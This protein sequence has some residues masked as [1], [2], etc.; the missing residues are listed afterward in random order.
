MST[1]TTSENY[2]KSALI[3]ASPLGVFR[4]ITEQIDEW[5]G[6]V[7]CQPSHKGVRFKVSFGEA[8]WS[9]R[10]TNFEPEHRVTWECIES[11]QV[12]AGLRG[13]KEEWLGTMLHW[14]ITS[15]EGG[16]SRL[17]FT[18]EGLVPDFNCYEVC[19][20]AWGFF[21]GTSLKQ[22][23]EKGEGEPELM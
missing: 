23:V 16:T 18:H 11:N 10:V 21:I 8:F 3:K 1:T 7:D 13:I 14:E 5:W 22:L 12:H 9:F 15:E 20:D 6:E 19:S 17:S 2:Q 4:A